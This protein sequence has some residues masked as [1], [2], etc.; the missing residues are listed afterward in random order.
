MLN[1]RPSGTPCYVL[2]ITCSMEGITVCSASSPSGTSSGKAAELPP[3]MATES[4]CG[5]VMV[6]QLLGES[7][8]SLRCGHHGEHFFSVD[9]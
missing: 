9:Q 7:H 4:R 6:T 8:C 5:W 3:E 2:D 1:L